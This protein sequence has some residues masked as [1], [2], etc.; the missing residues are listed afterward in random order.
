ML[1]GRE[2]EEVEYIYIYIF[3]QKKGRKD[4]SSRILAILM[5]FGPD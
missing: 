3:M 1:E 5:D 4:K 2:Q